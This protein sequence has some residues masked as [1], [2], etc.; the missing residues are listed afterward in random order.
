MQNKSFLKIS[1]QTDYPKL[2]IISEGGALNALEKAQR[3]KISIKRR[4]NDILTHFNAFFTESC[5]SGLHKKPD[6]KQIKK[7]TPIKQVFKAIIEHKKFLKLL[8]ISCIRKQTMENTLN[9]DCCSIK[10]FLIV[11]WLEIYF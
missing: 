7:P 11:Y 3:V 8:F 2:E 6:L 10:F 9:A 5:L 4:F 1:A